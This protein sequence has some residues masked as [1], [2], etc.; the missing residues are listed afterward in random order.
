MVP[1]GPARS[2]AALLAFTLVAPASILT[3]APPSGA[4]DA[5]PVFA[6]ASLRIYRVVDSAGLPRLLL[7]NLDADGN[8]LAPEEESADPT[9]RSEASDASPADHGRRESPDSPAEPASTPAEPA[10]EAREIHVDAGDD[11][12][13]RVDDGNGTTIIININPPP[14]AAPPEVA[15]VPAAVV[16]WVGWGSITG[17]YRYPEELPFLGYSP[18]I[19]SPSWF[20]GLGLNAG[21]GYGLST[22]KPCGRG[23]DC[24]FPPTA[25]QP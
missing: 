21:N 24:M 1:V 23:F 20:G 19:G 12:A 4:G 16:P 5:E 18:G 15:V 17:H 2:A 3:A 13:V 14:P 7:T 6:S 25:P 10:P 22:A 11:N 8:R 9:I